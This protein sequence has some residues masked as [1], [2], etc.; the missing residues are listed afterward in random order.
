MADRKKTP[1]TARKLGESANE[2]ASKTQKRAAA[3]KAGKSSPV[4]RKLK[5]AADKRAPARPPIVPPG[6]GEITEPVPFADMS[7]TRVSTVQEQPPHPHPSLHPGVANNGDGAAIAHQVAV[8][9]A[10]AQ[11]AHIAAIVT[12]RTGQL[13]GEARGQAN[14]PGPEA[15]GEA[16]NPHR[17]SVDHEM[18]TG[19]GAATIQATPLKP[20][21]ASQVPE[22][23]QAARDVVS[24]YTQLDAIL[25]PLKGQPARPGDNMAQDRAETI[26][27][28]ENDARAAIFTREVL[29]DQLQSETPDA[30][31]AQQ[32]GYVIRAL[33]S[34]ARRYGESFSSGVLSGIGKYAGEQLATLIPPLIDRLDH[35]ASLV[36]SLFTLPIW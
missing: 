6:Q 5:A 23:L 29:G 21:W 12:A 22:I 32:N 24:L 16:D 36:H 30:K 17:I 1:R 10:T 20:D 19:W 26:T 28:F 18:P 34:K 25:A 7:G 35:L 15:K 13:G 14:I 11:S 9:A 31:I 3:V 27:D 33:A 2:E 4:V 8:N